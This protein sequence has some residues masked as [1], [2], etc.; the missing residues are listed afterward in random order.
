M[1]RPIRSAMRTTFAIAQILLLGTA[2]LGL[3]SPLEILLGVIVLAL[4]LMSPEL[5]RPGGARTGRETTS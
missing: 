3:G 5:F 1:P 4:L 2:L